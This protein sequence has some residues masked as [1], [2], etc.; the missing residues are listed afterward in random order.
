MICA[1][2]CN[3]GAGTVATEGGGGT[4]ETMMVLPPSAKL[5]ISGAVA[6]TSSSA[7]PSRSAKTAPVMTGSSK[8]TLSWPLETTGSRLKV[9]RTW[10][11]SVAMEGFTAEGKLMVSFGGVLLS[12]SREKRIG[13]S[14]MNM[15]R[16]V[17]CN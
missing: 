16:A 2:T 8:L 12:R 11:G 4:A 14:P 10:P 7:N 6:I 1:G 13:T 15:R 3:C 9:K 17:G 5:A